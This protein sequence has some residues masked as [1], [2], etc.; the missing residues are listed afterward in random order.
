MSR[1]ITAAG[2]GTARQIGRFEVSASSE[3]VA[4]FRAATTFG[5]VPQQASADTLPLTYPLR[6]FNEGQIQD[7]ILAKLLPANGSASTLPL[8]VEQR[9]DIPTALALETPYWLHVS[10]TN[11][12]SN[13][14]VRISA[15]LAD[16]RGNPL[17]QMSS[18]LLMID[19]RQGTVT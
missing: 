14:M 3:C 7:A 17:G 2:H 11:A 13:Q 16:E 10:L 5:L 19:T 18:T 8:H 1:I 15:Q 4:E 6:W 9:L 12:D